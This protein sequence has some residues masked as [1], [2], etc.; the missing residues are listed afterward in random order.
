MRMCLRARVCVRVCARAP[1]RAVEL[2]PFQR[3]GALCVRVWEVACALEGGHEVVPAGQE[4]ADAEEHARPWVA[5]VA[6]VA[7]VPW[8]G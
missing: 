7:R 5:R 1:L 4:D 2:R 8:G 3:V 6:R